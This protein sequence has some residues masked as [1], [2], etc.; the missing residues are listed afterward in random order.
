[1]ALVG[2]DL[3]RIVP[4]TFRLDL[5]LNHFNHCLAKYSNLLVITLLPN[6]C[7]AN[8]KHSS[9]EHVFNPLPHR[10]TF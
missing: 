9:Y 8:Q 10:D 4:L 5:D 6:L 2:N 7:R 1:M 3:M